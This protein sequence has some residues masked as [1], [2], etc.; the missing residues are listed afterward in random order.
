MAYQERK[1][2]A[3]LMGQPEEYA[4]E[5]FLKGFLE[6][7]FKL[8]YDVCVFAM[9]IKY[10]NTPARSIGESSI[11]KIVNYE[12]FDCIVVMADTIQTKGVAERIE[13]ELHEG[14]SGKVLFVLSLDT[15]RQL[16]AGEGRNNA[17]YR[18]ARLQGH[19]VPHGQELAPAFQDKAAGLPRCAYGAR[20]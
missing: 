11:F 5:R 20:H 1:R 13:K 7:A 2:I 17:S 14:Y 9:F 3:V 15:H 10:Q 18:E 19:R 8:D 16:R 4:H 6:E 12:K